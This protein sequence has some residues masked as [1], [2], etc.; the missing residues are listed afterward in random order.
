MNEINVKIIRIS[1]VF[2]IMLGAYAFPL[3]AEDADLESRSENR[4]S[5]VIG[6]LSN[7]SP[8]ICRERWTPTAD[9]LSEMVKGCLFSIKP[10][11]YSELGLAIKGRKIDLLICDPAI[12]IELDANYSIRA[13]A[14]GVRWRNGHET[15]LFGG[16]VIAKRDNRDINDFKDLRGCRVAAIDSD[17]FAGWIVACRAFKRARIVPQRDFKSI[18]FTQDSTKVLHLVKDGTVDI[19]VIPT[20]TLEALATERNESDADFKV[21]RDQE[22]YYGEKTFP[23]HVSTRLYPDWPFAVLPHV[24]RALAEDVSIALIEM[25]RES[26]AAQSSSFRWSVPMSYNKIAECLQELQLGPY[27]GYGKLS[28]YN[29]FATYMVGVAVSAALIALLVVFLLILLLLTVKMRRASLSLKMELAERIKTEGELKLAK[30]AAEGADRAK[31]EFLAM[32]SHEIRTPLTSLL[33][34]A[35]LLRKTKLEE[36]QLKFV[37]I[38]QSSGESLL[39]LIN[40]ILD[41]AKIEAGKVE[42]DKTPFNLRECVVET[43]ELL[44]SKATTKKIPL[45]TNISDDVPAIVMGDE[46]RLRQILLNIAGNAVKFTDLGGVE[47]NVAKLRTFLKDGHGPAIQ[48]IKFEIKDTGI[49]IPADSI[50]ILFKPF[51]QA[52]KSINRNFGGTGL[53]LA[54]SRKLCDLMGGNI[55]V[56]SEYGVG[57]TFTCVL[58]LESVPDAFALSKPDLLAM[59]SNDNDDAVMGLK[60][61]LVDDHP[62][63]RLFASMVLER[64]GCQSEEAESG[65]EALKL[66][67][68]NSYDLILMDVRLPDIDG[69]EATRRIR[70]QSSLEKK[71]PFIIALTAQALAG[72]REK[73]LSA[74]MDAYLTK[75]CPPDLIIGVIK[76]AFVSRGFIGHGRS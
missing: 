60:A 64:I 29:F 67:R 18:V 28:L 5:I 52:D 41:L 73:C 59:E 4:N 27:K 34:F 24:S 20:M 15:Q 11:I 10:I 48:E 76:T 56:V 2:A 70:A 36:K 62:T 55:D 30:E 74:G 17:S 47:I 43:I 49:G 8:E 9:Y 23:F 31:S 69:L 50:P 51:N 45:K 21:I 54:I 38:I 6:V 72:D 13:I 75:P 32:M 37:E 61:L 7:E 25:P 58:Q 65:E 46:N 3:L 12:Y 39:L 68:L 19:G 53:G 35:G 42:L 44:Q 33:G 26:K 66:C 16:V 40:D 63:N 57:S 22:L 71:R 14:T 1:I